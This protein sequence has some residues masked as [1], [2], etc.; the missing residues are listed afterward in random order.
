[1]LW[2]KVSGAEI[3]VIPAV[4]MC[5]SSLFPIHTCNPYHVSKWLTNDDLLKCLRTLTYGERGSELFSRAG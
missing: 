5:K 2:L 4:L 1:V 3:G